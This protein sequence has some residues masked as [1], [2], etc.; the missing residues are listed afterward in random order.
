MAA[1]NI[2]FIMRFH[3]IHTI[4][5]FLNLEAHFQ[6]EYQYGYQKF[7]F[8]I[9]CMLINFV[10]TLA[11]SYLAEVVFDRGMLQFI[12]PAPYTSVGI[13]L[14]VYDHNFS[15]YFDFRRYIYFFTI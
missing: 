11:A 8:R 6:G 7:P 1:K 9:L 4:R 3:T 15:F 10:V 13:L 2:I 12:A 5:K 14:L